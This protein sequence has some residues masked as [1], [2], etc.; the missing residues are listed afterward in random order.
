VYPK[1]RTPKVYT[2]QALSPPAVKLPSASE[3]PKRSAI[4][5]LPI[6]ILDLIV[7]YFESV[8][9]EDPDKM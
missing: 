6:E 2:S 7:E 9:L 1:A 8:S 5:C 3:T 4:E